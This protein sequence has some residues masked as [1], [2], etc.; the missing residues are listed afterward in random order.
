MTAW[1]KR[2]FSEELRGQLRGYDA[3]EELAAGLPQ[4]FSAWDPLAQAQY[5]EIKTLLSGNLLSSQGDRMVMAHGVEARQ[6]FLDH[7][8][9][10]FCAALP[11]SLKLKGLQEKYLLKKAAEAYL[12]ASITGRT[13]QAYRAPDGASFFGEQAPSYVEPLLSGENISRTG[14]FNPESVSQ[15]ADKCRRSAGTLGARENLAMVGIVTTLLTDTHFCR[16]GPPPEFRPKP[17]TGF[18]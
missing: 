15:L 10:E 5:L 4:R 12:P 3:A 14:Y 8:L 18:A 2:L 1:T 6:P 7:R 16:G 13:K 11:P 9:A 17:A